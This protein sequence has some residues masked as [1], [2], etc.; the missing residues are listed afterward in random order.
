VKECPLSGSA[1]RACPGGAGA[2]PS[3]PG[4][5]PPCFDEGVEPLERA[6]PGGTVIGDDLEALGALGRRF[7]AVRIGDAAALAHVLLQHALAAVIARQHQRRVEPVRCE[8]AAG[9]LHVPVVALDDCLRAEPAGQL[10]PV[11]AR[12]DRQH[13]GSQT[14]GELQRDVPHSSAGAEDE[15]ALPRLEPQVVL[16][17]L[18]C[19]DAVGRERRRLLHRHFP[20]NPRRVLLL[21]HGELRVEA[22][23]GAQEGDGVDAVPLLEALHVPAHGEHLA[24]AVGAGHVGEAWAPLHH[25]G[26]RW[27]FAQHL[28]FAE[29]RPLP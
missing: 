20:G 6:L 2:P 18:Q 21:H 29:R 3:G 25:P 22:P 12:G 1:G 17:P 28:P 15:Q 7:H 27:H 8:V 24:R 5:P 13:P 26:Q 10:H 14:P 11:F 16:E 9:L 4:R 23:L 19:G